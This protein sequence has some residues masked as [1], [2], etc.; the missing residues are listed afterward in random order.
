MAHD[1][2]D[3]YMT[4]ELQVAIGQL[5]V[6]IVRATNVDELFDRLVA[7]GEDHED[8]VDERIPYWAELWPSGIGLAQFLAGLPLAGTTVTELGC[9][10]GLSGI[11]AGML[12]AEVTLTDYLD[13][14]IQFAR[15]NW[16]LN[17]ANPARFMRLDWREPDPAVTA[18]WLIASD[19]TYEKRYF[20]YLPTAFRTMCKPGGKILVS[21]PRRHVSGAFFDSLPAQGFKVEK[22]TLMVPSLVSDKE[23]PIDVYVIAE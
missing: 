13:E 10:L 9:G 22:H 14:A 23:N 3:E 1:F 20:Q 2:S 19:I 11:V 8:V 6:R 12:G 5:Q 17:C 21:D 15:Y 18:D 4:A 16:S 7:K